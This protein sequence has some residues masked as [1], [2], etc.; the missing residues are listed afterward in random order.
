MTPEEKIDLLGGFNNF[1]I[2]GVAR[3][4][5]PELGTSDSPFGIRADGPSTVFAAGIG[6]AATWNP[7]LAEKVGAQ[8]GRDARARGRH[9]NLGPGVNIYRLPL[10]GRNFEYYGEDPWLAS[11]IAVGYIRGEQSQGVSATIKHYLGNNSE[12]ARQRSSHR[13]W[14]RRWSSECS[15][16]SSR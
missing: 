10:N 5:V 13:D 16:S 7:E 9:Y 12:Y 3:L 15:P 4:G 2:H 6:L 11:R 1:D 8:V 14:I